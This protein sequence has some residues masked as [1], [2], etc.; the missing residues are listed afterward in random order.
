MDL[1]GIDKD[2]ESWIP[3]AIEV[4]FCPTKW[5]LDRDVFLEIHDNYFDRYESIYLRLHHIKASQAK[6]ERIV[7]LIQSNDGKTLYEGAK[8]MSFW[9]YINDT[10]VSIESKLRV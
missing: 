3:A 1:Y 10:Q 4:F 5:R 9:K 6:L 7:K 8:S 2:L